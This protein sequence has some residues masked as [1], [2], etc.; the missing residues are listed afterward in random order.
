M[1]NVLKCFKL[2][3]MNVCCVGILLKKEVPPVI[4]FKGSL[5]FA[6]SSL[7]GLDVFSYMKFN[8]I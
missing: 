6:T 8:V 7:N 4:H 2:F 1:F 5:I 3:R